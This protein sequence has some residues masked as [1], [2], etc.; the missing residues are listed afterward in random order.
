[1][2]ERHFYNCATKGLEDDTLFGSTAAFIAGMNRVAICLLLTL[3]SS[4]LIIM[5]FCLMDNHVHFILYCTEE[6][7]KRFLSL[8]KRLTEIWLTNH[9]EQGSPGK[10]WDIGHWL[11]KDRDNLIEKINYVH[12]NPT[13]AH[14]PF[15]PRGYRW[16]SGNLLFTDH[17]FTK[18]I[19]RK[20][21]DISRNEKR[22]MFESKVAVPDD[23][24]VLP[25]GM[26]WPGCYVSYARVEKLFSSVFNYMYELNKRCEEKVNKEMMTDFISLPDGEIRSKAIEL[27]QQLFSTEFL[28][29]LSVDQRI[30]LAK[31]LRKS[32]GA[33]SKQIARIVRMNLTE[34]RKLI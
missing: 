31:E 9:P 2:E 33:S 12:R 27:S 10:K 28:P 21:S 16:S 32:M 14:M 7:C 22:R 26:I 3:E 1:M 5:A 18:S 20:A 8:Y 17:A 6:T 4:P 34:L 15:T 29:G 24:L 23:W 25:D 30:L 13:A 19:C 11:I